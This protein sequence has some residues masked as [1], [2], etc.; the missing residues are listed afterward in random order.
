MYRSFKMKLIK[1]LQ[2]HGGNCDHLT[3]LIR[4]PFVPLNTHR[5]QE[6]THIHTRARARARAH[7]RTHAHTHARAHA[8]TH[9]H[10]HK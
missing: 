5:M 1:W 3:Q 2:N 8:R 10:T 9:K 4:Q 7:A 6:R